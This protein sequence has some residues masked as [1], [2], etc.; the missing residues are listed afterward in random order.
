MTTREAIKKVDIY[1]ISPIIVPVSTYLDIFS[2]VF[3]VDPCVR[4]APD[5]QSE[6]ECAECRGDQHDHQTKQ[7]LVAGGHQSSVIE[8]DKYSD[9]LREDTHKIS[10]IRVEG[11]KS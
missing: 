9:E 7:S 6:D 4:V 5:E 8:P 1:K 3:E 2:L 11:K 10:V